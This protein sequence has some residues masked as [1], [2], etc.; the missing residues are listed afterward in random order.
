MK[1]FI[2]ER[3]WLLC[4]LVG[5]GLVLVALA[6]GVVTVAA[7]R[8]FNPM[9]LAFLADFEIINDSARDV[10]VTPIGMWQGS[11]RY[12]SLPRYRDNYPPVLT[13]QSHDVPVTA[14]RSVRITYDWDDI[15]FRHILVRTSSGECYMLDTDKKGTLQS[16]YAAEKERYRIPPLGDLPR[17]PAELIPC[18]RGESV[19]YPGAKEYPENSVVAGKSSPGGQK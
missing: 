7:L 18:T 5:V 15:N 6:A 19:L 2:S 9:L 14:G 4:L 12:G 13:C 8:A 1:Q 17:A 3:A 16:C 10:S 11:G